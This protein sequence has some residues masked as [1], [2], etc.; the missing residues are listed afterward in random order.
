MILIGYLRQVQIKDKVE[1]EELGI[2][3]L[4]RPGICY[5]L[6]SNAVYSNV[7]QKHTEPEIL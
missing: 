1:Q 5:R 4:Y 7:F 2:S 6:Y 3:F